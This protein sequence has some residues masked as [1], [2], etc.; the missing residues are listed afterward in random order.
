MPRIYVETSVISYLANRTSRDGLVAAR[1]ALTHDW[2]AG[3]DLS[4]VW[5]SE[6]V[7]AE[8]ARGDPKA[9]QA[10][11]DWIVHLPRVDIDTASRELAQRLMQAGLIPKTEPED[12]LHIAMASVHGFDYLA[13]WNFAHFVGVEP[14]YR[15]FFALRE[16]GLH[17]TLLVTPE[18]FIE[19]VRQ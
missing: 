5:I 15:L 9:A 16:W 18:E 8:I 3:L 1:Q 11:L 13:T 17:A 2:W 19:G 7:A 10:R 12:A 14:K 4:T 6:L